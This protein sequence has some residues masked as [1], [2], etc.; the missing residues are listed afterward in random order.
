MISEKEL[1]MYKD[2]EMI[3]ISHMILSNSRGLFLLFGL[4]VVLDT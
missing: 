2:S 1:R 3:L 4:F